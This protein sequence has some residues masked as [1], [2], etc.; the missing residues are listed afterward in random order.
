M[1][2]IRCAE[3]DNEIKV[4]E[5]RFNIV[6]GPIC[7]NCIDEKEKSNEKIDSDSVLVKFNNWNGSCG[8]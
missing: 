3:C 4:G 6:N 1:S 5:G 8:K 7:I 2:E